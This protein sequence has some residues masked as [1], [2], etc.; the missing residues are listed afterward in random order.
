[1]PLALVAAGGVCAEDPGAALFEQHCVVCHQKQG[2]G[3]PGLA[4]RLANNLTE[5]A[6]NESGR[7]YL[8]QLVVSGMMGPIVSGG[9]PFNSAMPTF[10]A[11]SDE[12]IVAVVGY[13]LGEL[14]GVP[15]EQRVT[16]QDVAAARQRALPPHEVRRMRGK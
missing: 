13:V 7:A 12:E 5:H 14:N 9:E 4:P 11:L 1:M 8:A 15:A 10:V 16:Q 6:K 2:E 3:A